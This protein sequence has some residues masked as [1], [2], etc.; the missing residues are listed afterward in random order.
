MFVNLNGMSC[1]FKSCNHA[2]CIIEVISMI[3]S[4]GCASSEQ[5]G[6]GRWPVHGRG[7]LARP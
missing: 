1:V 5:A 7:L 6:R 3:M 2:S 4:S